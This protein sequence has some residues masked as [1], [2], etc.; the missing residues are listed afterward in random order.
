MKLS[1]ERDNLFGLL[2]ELVERINQFSDEDMQLM[3]TLGTLESMM[4]S[5]DNSGSGPILKCDSELFKSVKENVNTCP[6]PTT[7]RFQ[8]VIEDRSPFREL[9]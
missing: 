3:G 9:N 8:S 5:F 6:S 2:T 7:K 4:Q 1:S